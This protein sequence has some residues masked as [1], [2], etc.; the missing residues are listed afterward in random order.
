MQ[1]T[2]NSSAK[3][4]GF[5]GNDD[6]ALGELTSVVYAELHRIARRVWGLQAPG[7]TL[8]PT[9]LIHEAY[10]KL[11]KQDDRVFQNRAHFLA[12]ASIA[13]RQVLVN[14]AESRLTA[15]RG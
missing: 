11:V 10:L 15:K 2:N 6:H 14:H 9:V 5:D 8:Q 3:S 7:H 12:V 1:P 4:A 13:M